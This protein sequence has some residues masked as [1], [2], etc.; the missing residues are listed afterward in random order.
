MTGLALDTSDMDM[1]VCGLPI[2]DRTTMVDDLHTLA[3]EVEKWKLLK[4]M[5]LIDTAT[6]PVIKANLSY[7]D[8]KNEMNLTDDDKVKELIGETDD[9]ELLED[10]KEEAFLPIDITFDDNTNTND[11]II[12]AYQKQIAETLEEEKNAKLLKESKKEEQSE[13]RESSV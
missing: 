5:K 4:D 1:V 13:K 6:I 8:I 3:I 2:A 11:L 7:W 12:E 9:D 10:E